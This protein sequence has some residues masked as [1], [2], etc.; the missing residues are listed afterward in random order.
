ML[1]LYAFEIVCFMLYIEFLRYIYVPYILNTEY[2]GANEICWIY[3]T[4]LW[5]PSAP[6]AQFWYVLKEVKYGPMVIVHVICF[7]FFF[8]FFLVCLFIS[9]I[10]QFLQ[11]P[12][13]TTDIVSYHVLC[14]HD[15][16]IFM[17]LSY[18]MKCWLVCACICRICVCVCAFSSPMSILPHSIECFGMIICK[19][20]FHFQ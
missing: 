13:L 19:H 3:P 11:L 15:I 8:V 17:V 2:I 9:I 12:A 18:G 20:V 10:F 16:R 1:L 6:L 14:C 7:M 5:L 4:R